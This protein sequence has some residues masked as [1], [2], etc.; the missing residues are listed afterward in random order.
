MFEYTK[1]IEADD[2]FKPYSG[3]SGKGVYFCRLTFY[4][5]TI[6]GFLVRYLEEVKQC[7]VYIQ[8]RIPNPDEKQLAFFEEIIGQSFEMDRDFL[9]NKLKKWLPRLNEFQKNSIAVSLLS[10]LNDMRRNGKN[11]NMLKNAYIKFM[12]W[13]Y[14]KFERIL[15]LLGEDR[16]PKILYEGNASKYELDMLHILSHAGCDVLLLE[17]EGDGLYLKADPGGNRT[18]L[19]SSSQAEPFPP[20][21]TISKLE[22]SVIEERNAPKLTIPKPEG[23]VSTNTWISGNVFEDSLKESQARGNQPSYYYNMF[24]RVSG[25]EDKDTWLNELLRWKLKLE[26][27]RKKV[28]IIEKNVP[29]PEAAE[30][31]KIKRKNYQN[32][33]QMIADLVNHISIPKCRELE[34]L[35]KLAFIGIMEEDKTSTPQKLMNRAVCLLC[36]LDRYLTKLFEGWQLK[37]LPTVL[38]YGVLNHENE[39]CF[40]RLLSRLPVDVF[41]ICT[42]LSQ[43]YTLEDKLLFEKRY[44]QSLPLGAF[45]KKVENVSFGTTAFHAERDLDTIMYQDTGVYRNRQFKKAIPVRLKTTY[46][47]IGILWNQEAVF[48][49][50]FETFDDRVMV[51]VIA[52]RICGVPGND[53]A[54]YWNTISGM[55]GEDTF[56]VTKLPYIKN[57]DDNP[58]RQLAT[59]FLADHR[60]KS[61]KIKA[62]P[63]YPYSFVREEMQD[64]MM[65]KLCELLDSGII[66][67]TYTAGAEYSI[68]AAALNLDKQLVRMIQKYDFTKEIPKLVVLTTGEDIPSLEDSILTAY[69]SF[70]G[71]DVVI[72]VP[73][74]YQ[75]VERNFTSELF[76]EHQAGEYRYDLTVPYFKTPRKDSQRESLASKL[77]RRRK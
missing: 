7:G 77:F 11:D 21:F 66:K 72:F 10:I 71:F 37:S 32:S 15:T 28:I 1:L 13:F 42:D 75:S 48:R 49:P 27:G 30:I 26:S 12:C 5:A 2:Y 59:G 44:E 18:Q 70:L 39:A 47:E 36:W 14:Y 31:Q 69:L 41:L 64:Y 22:R 6:R 56:M 33:Q 17:C 55:L 58:M 63:A 29:S 68:V 35:V 65:D 45:P 60:L 52:S 51:P 3:R 4:N 53:A 61:Q 74:G 19:L 16:L 20:G 54:A 73:T 46:E 62:H 50:N 24:V 34:K 43:N 23:V 57:T 40:F 25:A 67:G 9:N 8:D 76:V 38:F